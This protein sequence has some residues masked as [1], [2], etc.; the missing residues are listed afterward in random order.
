MKPG[1]VGMGAAVVAAGALAALWVPVGLVG[2]LCLLALLRICWLEDNIVSDLF[3]R[4]RLPPG[5]RSTAE[6]RR[7]FF[8]RWFGIRPD[9]AGGEGSAHLLAT[10]MRAEVQIWA[11]VLLGVAAALVAQ[12]GMFG[13]PVNLGLGATLF[14]VAL[15]RADRLA[16]SLAHCDSGQPLPDHMLVPR[17]RRI[18]AARKR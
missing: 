15:T 8:F 10:A 3:G 18:L 13:T 14:V 2:A 1:H 16:L 9:D 4:D 11:S 5:Y 12:R 17:S 6:M 7:L